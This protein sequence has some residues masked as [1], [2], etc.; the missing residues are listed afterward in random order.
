MLKDD[1]FVVKPLTKNKFIYKIYAVINTSI[2]QNYLLNLIIFFHTK[3]LI[4]PKKTVNNNNTDFLQIRKYYYIKMLSE[5]A[6]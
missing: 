3:K 2:S 6:K 1:F 4:I 5:K